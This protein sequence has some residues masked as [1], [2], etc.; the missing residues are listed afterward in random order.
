MRAGALIE[1]HAIVLGFIPLKESDRLAHLLTQDHGRIAAVAPQAARSLKRFGAALEPMSHIKAHLQ[2]PREGREGHAVWRLE[3]ADLQSSFL[4]FRK[5]YALLE[6]AFFA[7]RLVMDQIPEGHVDPLLF[8]ALGR[9]LKYS[10]LEGIEKYPTYLR[11]AFWTW[12]AQHLGLGDLSEKLVPTLGPLLET[13]HNVLSQGE[14]P[15]EQLFK[16]IIRGQS[17]DLTPAQEI[18]IYEK[19]LQNSA[20]HWPYFEQWLQSRR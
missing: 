5:S 15:F 9:F 11:V 4:H 17:K 12:F 10:D 1:S 6:T 7:L 19:W 13:W 8:R 3:R 16:E 18:E 14:V 2:I 20:M